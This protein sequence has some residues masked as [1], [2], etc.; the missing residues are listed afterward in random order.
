VHVDLLILEIKELGIEC[1]EPL[2]LPSPLPFGTPIHTLG[3]KIYGAQ[4]PL[5]GVFGAR[6]HSS[7]AP[8][9]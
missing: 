2:H 9:S 3:R 1:A 8:E 7:A 4:G 6:T 5:A